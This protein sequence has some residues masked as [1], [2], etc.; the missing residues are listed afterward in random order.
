MTH[1]NGSLN[2]GSLGPWEPAFAM[3]AVCWLAVR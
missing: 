2:S 3:I 1:N